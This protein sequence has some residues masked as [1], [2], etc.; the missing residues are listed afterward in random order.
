MNIYLYLKTA[1]SLEFRVT[2]DFQYLIKSKI[3]FFLMFW[4]K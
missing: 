2:L 1:Y 4:L 3:D